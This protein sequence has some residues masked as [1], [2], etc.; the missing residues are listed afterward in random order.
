MQASWRETA[1]EVF[2][3]IRDWQKKDIPAFTKLMAFEVA[4]LYFALEQ[5]EEAS[6]DL[7]YRA[8]RWMA[9]AHKMKE[10]MKDK[11]G[12]ALYKRLL[13]LFPELTPTGEAIIASRK[14]SMSVAEMAEERTALHL[15]QALNDPSYFPPPCARPYPMDFSYFL[16]HFIVGHIKRDDPRAK[17]LGV[18]EPMLKKYLAG[19]SVPLLKTMQ[20]NNWG[21]SLAQW[22]PR[23]WTA[24]GHMLYSFGA[25]S[26]A[27]RRREKNPNWWSKPHPTWKVSRPS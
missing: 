25:E 22:N 21:A 3:E 12:E 7:Y 18:S 26:I 1:G 17:A 11:R 14:P 27:A 10:H 2:R 16:G 20:D 4:P 15:A 8:A 13:N 24:Y 9:G 23:F 19:K 5:G 6:R